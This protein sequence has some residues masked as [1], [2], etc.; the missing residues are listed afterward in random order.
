MFSK[1]VQKPLSAFEL[2]HTLFYNTKDVL[3]RCEMLYSSNCN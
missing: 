1:T 2:C 3:E